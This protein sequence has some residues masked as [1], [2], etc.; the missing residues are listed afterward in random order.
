[1]RALFKSTTKAY[2]LI[3]MELLI[4]YL[5]SIKPLSADLE[6]WL[7]KHL[8]KIRFKKGDFIL[9]DGQVCDNIYFLEVGLIRIFQMIQKKTGVEEMTTWIQ[10]EG[11]IFISIVSF[12][13]R[14]PSP[15]MIEAL[16]DCFAWYISFSELEKATELYP[17]FNYHAS[18]IKSIYHSINHERVLARML[19]L[20]E[21]Y[22]QFLDK[23][24]WLLE[25]VSNNHLASYM[26]I[27]LSAFY[28]I[29]NEL[30]KGK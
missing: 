28:K 27:S 11:E 5:N 23:Q 1:M 24:P 10:K 30:S 15:E 7:R 17:E 21:R 9:R 25:R 29:R 20:K 13:D 18:R 2:Y 3:C 6:A 16:E 8:R 22:N 4:A 26:G 12:F 14:V 19:D